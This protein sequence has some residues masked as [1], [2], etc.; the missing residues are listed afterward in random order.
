MLA[1]RQVGGAPEEVPAQAGLLAPLNLDGV[2]VTADALQ[3]HPEAAELLVTGKRACRSSR[4]AQL[5]SPTTFADTGPS[6]TACTGSAT[7]PSP[8]TPAGSAPAPAQ[9][10]WQPCATWPSACSAIPGR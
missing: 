8:R 5:G 2:L 3:T 10:S 6:R 7:S 9:P 4:A 1:Q